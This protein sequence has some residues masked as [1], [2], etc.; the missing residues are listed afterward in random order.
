[1]LIYCL[2]DHCEYKHIFFS[3]L[4]CESE[5][6]W[7]FISMKSLLWA[8]SLYPVSSVFLLRQCFTHINK[9]SNYIMTYNT[10]IGSWNRNDVTVEVS[11]TRLPHP[12]CQEKKRTKALWENVLLLIILLLII[13]GL[14]NRDL[15]TMR[16]VAPPRHGVIIWC[17][18]HCDTANS[19][20]AASLR[21]AVSD[22]QPQMGCD[23][24]KYQTP[25]DWGH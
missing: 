4:F 16:S 20:V 6:W 19:V 5:Q 7:K 11:H 13:K 14:V 17:V 15:S 8:I 3:G 9:H 21:G 25:G 22:F 23:A 1:M 2:C 18:S 12:S 24:L 10:V